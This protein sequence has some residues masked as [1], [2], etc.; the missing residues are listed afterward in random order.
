[1]T[2][3][4]DLL[5]RL[6]DEVRQAAERTLGRPLGD[7][8]IDRVAGV[9][10]I[11]DLQSCLRAWASEAASPETVASDILDLPV[12][13]PSGDF[14]RANQCEHWLIDLLSVLFGGALVAVGLFVALFMLLAQMNLHPAKM[15]HLAIM[16][17]GWPT[18]PICVF[19][20]FRMMFR[21]TRRNLRG[22]VWALLMLALFWL[23]LWIDGGDGLMH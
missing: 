18:I 10:S 5:I 12:A 11:P 15:T 21:Q 14:R 16:A 6:R 2:N 17:T 9:E 23:S 13:V 1:M 7:S 4:A 3:E 20:G 8:E 22:G 19:L